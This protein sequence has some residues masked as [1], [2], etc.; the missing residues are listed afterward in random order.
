MKIPPSYQLT[1]KITSLLQE[2]EKLSTTLSL[3]PQTELAEKY[4]R[5]KN[6]LK[7][8]DYSA[9]I[10]GN[11]QRASGEKDE[12][13]LPPRRY[14]ILQVIRDHRQTSFDFIRRRFLAVSPRML[15]YDLKR[16]RDKGLIK[17][18]GITKGVV[19]EPIEN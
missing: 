15:R 4:T 14:E 5:Q 8:S 12:D 9:R 18:R 7:S 3:L 1:K 10:E 16:L 19:Y 11:Q 2:I 17:K 13:S 6:L